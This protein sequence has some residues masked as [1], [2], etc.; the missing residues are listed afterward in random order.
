MY[1][2]ELFKKLV[3]SPPVSAGALI[4]VGESIWAVYAVYV[5]LGMQTFLCLSLYTQGEST[6]CIP[7]LVALNLVSALA[8]VPDLSN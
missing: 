4:I 6:K 8:A 2:L 5:L 7:S 3:Y 1:F